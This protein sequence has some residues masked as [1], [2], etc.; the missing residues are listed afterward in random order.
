M[1][2]CPLSFAWIP[3]FV[4]SIALFFFFLDFFELDS[5]PIVSRPTPSSELASEYSLV[6][7]TS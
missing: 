4:G 2:L 5:A 6:L 3:F 1:Q 7:S